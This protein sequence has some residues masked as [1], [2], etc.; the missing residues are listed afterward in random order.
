MPAAT[1]VCLRFAFLVTPLVQVL[2]H[3]YLDLYTKEQLLKL[4]KEAKVTA[5]TKEELATKQALIAAIIQHAP[6]GV[7]AQGVSEDRSGERMTTRNVE[8]FTAFRNVGAELMWAHVEEHVLE[9]PYADL[10]RRRRERRRDVSEKA[11]S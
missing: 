7:R 9:C 6:P 1:T 11:A 10:A 4:G 2:S 8:D 3:E 5:F